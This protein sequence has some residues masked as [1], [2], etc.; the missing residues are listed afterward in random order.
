MELF[1]LSL[2]GILY[3][4]MMQK[5]TSSNKFF[6]VFFDGV[7]FA[8]TFRFL[9]GVIFVVTSRFFH[10]VSSVY[11]PSLAFNLESIFCSAPHALGDQLLAK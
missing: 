1:L 5:S 6:W 9:D 7:A 8:G 3:M 11:W 10:G 4:Q 2:E